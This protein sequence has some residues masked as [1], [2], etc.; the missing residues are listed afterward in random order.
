VGHH[1]SYSNGEHGNNS[2][3]ITNLEPL[4]WRYNVAAYF[5]GHD[6]NLELLSVPAPGG[7]ARSYAVVVSGGGSKTNRPQ[8][9]S[10]YS[11]YYHPDQ[12]FV[13][14]TVTQDTLRLEYY[15][16]KG[17]EKAAFSTTIKRPTAS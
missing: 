11:Q 12:G 8:V 7:S 16:T 14:A 1:P 5:V 9:G 10:A 6:H 17:G 2:D 13:G 15:T 3:I 4:F